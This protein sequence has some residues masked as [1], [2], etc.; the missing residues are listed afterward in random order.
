MCKRFYNPILVLTFPPELPLED[1]T[2]PTLVHR[3]KKNNNP[4]T[5]FQLHY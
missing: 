2:Q 4:N 1:T 5:P 3:Q